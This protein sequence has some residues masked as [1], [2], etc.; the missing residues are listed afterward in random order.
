MQG[1]KVSLIDYFIIYNIICLG[2]SR[3]RSSRSGK[4]TGGLS[5]IE[6]VSQ[7]IEHQPRRH[8][9]TDFSEADGSSTSRNPL[10]PAEK[11]RR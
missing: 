8:K 11:K 9:K 5:H 7:A 10:A 2:S 4:V 3:R 1:T 6:K